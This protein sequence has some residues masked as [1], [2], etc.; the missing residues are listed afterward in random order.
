MPA[1]H[2]RSETHKVGRKAM[3][4]KAPLAAGENPP[5]GATTTARTLNWERL[6]ILYAR[7]ALEIG[8]SQSWEESNDG[9]GTAGRRGKSTARR[10]DN[11]AYP[12]LG[13]TGNPLCP[14][15]T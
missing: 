3:M 2:L 4:G 6:G 14:H 13:A 12:E 10:N 1:L 11:S 15:C 7:I 9:Q 5:R 8:N